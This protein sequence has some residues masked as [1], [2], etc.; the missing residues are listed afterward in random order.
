MYCGARSRNHH[1]KEGSQQ[2][3]TQYGGM[4]LP[5]QKR[6]YLANTEFE[7]QEDFIVDMVDKPKPQIETRPT[8]ESLSAEERKKHVI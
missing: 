1:F 7:V 5:P 2:G 6:E 8:L 3:N 4:L